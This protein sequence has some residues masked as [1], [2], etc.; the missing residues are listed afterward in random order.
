MKFV[1]D[2]DVKTVKT[3]T[4]IVLMTDTFMS[5][6]GEARGGVGYAGWACNPTDA[7]RVERWVRSRSDARNV[8]RVRKDYRPSSRTVGHCHIYV[9]GPNHPAINEER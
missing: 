7:E 5:G 1:S 6:W 8:R 3:H 2:I 9:V 4:T